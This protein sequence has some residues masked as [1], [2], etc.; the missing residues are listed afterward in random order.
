[1]KLIFYGT[2]EKP[3]QDNSNNEGDNNY[4]CHDECALT[5][6]GPERHHCHRCKGLFYIDENGLQV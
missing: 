4:R 3:G 6:F 5:C 2:E 1:M